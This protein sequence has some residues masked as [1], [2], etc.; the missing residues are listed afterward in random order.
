MALQPEQE[1]TEEEPP[2]VG[3]LRVLERLNNAHRLGHGITETTL[4][5]EVPLTTADRE[6]VFAALS[7]LKLIHRTD[8]EEL[9]LGRSLD[10]VTLWDLYERLPDRVVFKT[11][12]TIPGMPAVAARLGELA[13]D[14]RQRLGVSLGGLLENRSEESAP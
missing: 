7:D 12:V 1:P 6:R 2:L 8:T 14:G 4:T 3:A 5:R 13:S 10:A 11:P 9:A